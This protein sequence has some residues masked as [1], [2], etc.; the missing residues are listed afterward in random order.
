MSNIVTKKIVTTTKS[1]PKIHSL[2]WKHW[3]H[4]LYAIDRGLHTP[5]QFFFSKKNIGS[6]LYMQS[7][8]GCI[9][10]K[11]SNIFRKLHS[12]FLF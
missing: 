9:C 11:L 12:N 7:I 2:F 4:T 5:T 8:E 1:L 3:L 6:I 10:L